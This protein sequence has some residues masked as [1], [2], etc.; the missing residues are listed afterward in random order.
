MEVRFLS[1]GDGSQSSFGAWRVDYSRRELGLL[2]SFELTGDETADMAR[3]AEVYAGREGY[4]H[5]N[6]SPIRLL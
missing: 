1:H 5:E 6:A 2:A 4:H 3:I